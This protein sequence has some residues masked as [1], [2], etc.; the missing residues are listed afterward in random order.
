MTVEEYLSRVSSQEITDQMA[1]D[2]LEAV[3]RKWTPPPQPERALPESV[4]ARL[5]RAFPPV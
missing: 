5:D 3:D 4:I 1:F 2:M